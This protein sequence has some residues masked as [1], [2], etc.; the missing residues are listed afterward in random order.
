MYSAISEHDTSMYKITLT[1]SLAGLS[2]SRQVEASAG[3]CLTKRK[4]NERQGNATIQ[5]ASKPQTPSLVITSYKP[6]GVAG[7][8]IPLA[9]FTINNSPDSRISM[10]ISTSPSAFG[11]NQASICSSRAFVQIL[12]QRYRLQLSHRP[13]H[14]ASQAINHGVSPDSRYHW[15]SSRAIFA[16]FTDIIGDLHEP[17]TDRIM[18][19]RGPT[20]LLLD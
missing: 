10:A 14:Q 3:S 18:I 17:I 9:I 1:A 8:T 13:H 7:F 16:G 2:Q 4:T 6:W 11:N 12:G 20:C 5:V 19:F 15:R